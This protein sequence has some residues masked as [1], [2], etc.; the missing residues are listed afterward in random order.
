MTS[1]FDFSSSSFNASSGFASAAFAPSEGADAA[2]CVDFVCSASV[3]C[4]LRCSRDGTYADVD[5]R[6]EMKVAEE[7]GDRRTC[8]NSVTDFERE[9]DWRSNCFRSIVM[10]ERVGVN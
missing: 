1:R 7:N 9:R 5:A 4:H 3:D 8:G 10:C 6:G 2:S